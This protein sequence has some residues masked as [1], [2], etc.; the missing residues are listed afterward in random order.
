MFGVADSA[1]T[2]RDEKLVLR[3]TESLRSEVWRCTDTIR[4]LLQVAE[5]ERSVAMQGDGEGGE[6]RTSSSVEITFFSNH[7]NL[8]CMHE[9]NWLTRRREKRL[10]FF[11]IA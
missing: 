8:I 2:Y 6:S 5:V 7:D 3:S 10:S 9:D 11:F 4:V 1:E